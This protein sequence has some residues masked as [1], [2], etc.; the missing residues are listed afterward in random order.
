MNNNCQQHLDMD[1]CRLLA[2]T[3][4]ALDSP[5]HKLCL[6][7]SFTSQPRA[8]CSD[9]TLEHL[10]WHYRG[11]MPASMSSVDLIHDDW[12]GLA[13]LASPE[14]LSEVSSISSRASS[15]CRHH[16][17]K[18]AFVTFDDCP[19]RHH[20]E[21]EDSLQSDPPAKSW[22]QNFFSSEHFACVRSNSQSDSSPENNSLDENNDK[23]YSTESMTNGNPGT[24]K[25]GERL[26]DENTLESS[27]LLSSLHLLTDEKFQN[28]FKDQP[29]KRMD[30]S[31]SSG[32]FKSVSSH[33][34]NLSTSVDSIT[35]NAEVHRTDDD[36]S[37]D[38][39]SWP[40]DCDLLEDIDRS[41][42]LRGC[43][44][45]FNFGMSNPGCSVRVQPPDIN[46]VILDVNGA[47]GGGKSKYVY[48]ILSV[49]PGESSV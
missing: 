15:I 32:S 35:I 46:R 2:G 23:F 26:D 44:S 42:K 10:P 43:D 39:V 20:F 30:D 48:P 19:V 11:L 4:A 24:S 38:K 31:I 22:R 7:T 16:K 14:S 3:A 27:P 45:P 6:E 33:I 13:P 1:H 18:P 29:I 9:S 40:D 8:G 25:E 21:R 49:G 47:S 36:L 41:L 37:E 34:N 12:F 28:L 5:P 17:R